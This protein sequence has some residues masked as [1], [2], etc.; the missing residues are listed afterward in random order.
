MSLSLGFLIYNMEMVLPRVV[1]SEQ[2][3][4]MGRS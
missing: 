2:D 4:S 1:R 3:E